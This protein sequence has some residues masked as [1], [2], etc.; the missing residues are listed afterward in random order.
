MK[1]YSPLN[2]KTLFLHRTYLQDE[3]K[4]QEYFFGTLEAAKST[5]TA[6]TEVTPVSA[7]YYVFDGWFVDLFKENTQKEEFEIRGKKVIPDY[8]VHHTVDLR[9]KKP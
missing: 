1:D 6:Y 8:T 2:K 4:W 7:K 5:V 9:S 3:G